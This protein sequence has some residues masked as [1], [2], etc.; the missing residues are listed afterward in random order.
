MRNNQTVKRRRMS[1]FLYKKQRSPAQSTNRFQDA[2]R[3]EIDLLP[4]C[5]RGRSGT[6]IRITMIESVS[7]PKVKHLVLLREKSRARNKEGL[8]PV[9]GI[10]MF[11]EAP[12]ER[13][14]EVYVGRTLWRQKRKAAA[15][16][17]LRRYMLWCGKS[18]APV[19]KGESMWSRC[20]TRC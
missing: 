12:Y 18:S 17:R 16:I 8:F 11:A 4:V 5:R 10:K 20:P 2:K 7:N 14:R 15:G 6:G 13:I 19:W 9:E 1:A 3:P